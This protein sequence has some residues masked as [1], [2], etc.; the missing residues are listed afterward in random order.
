MKF[1]VRY[2]RSAKREIG[3]IYEYY[4][5]NAP[6]FAERWFAGVFEAAA[7]LSEFPFRC[8]RVPESDDS[9]E[10]VRH[11]LFGSHRILYSVRGRTVFI[12]HVRHSSQQVRTRE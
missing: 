10:E 11:L 4:Q 3:A 2:T 12:L 6:T 5:E 7:T 9:P 1:R 8:A